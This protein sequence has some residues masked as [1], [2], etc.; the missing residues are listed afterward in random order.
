MLPITIVIP[1]PVAATYHAFDMVFIIVVVRYVCYL[2]SVFYW[3]LVSHS[4]TYSVALLI[5]GKIALKFRY[6]TNNYCHTFS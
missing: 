5:L 4:S 2:Q 1:F 6:A 3:W